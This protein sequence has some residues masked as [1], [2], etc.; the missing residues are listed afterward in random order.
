METQNTTTI[1]VSHEFKA[2]LSTH[3]RF[4]E[5]FEDILIRLLGKEFEESATGDRAIKTYSA[6]D[7]DSKKY[8]KEKLNNGS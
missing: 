6:K 5:R 3:G 8:K 2:R 1:R 4:G 7:V